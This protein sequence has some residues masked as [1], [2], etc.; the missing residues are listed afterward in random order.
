M[1]LKK[2]ISVLL[3]VGG[4]LWSGT[5]FVKADNDEPSAP[6]EKVVTEV[7]VHTGKITTATLHGYVEGFGTVQPAPATK[8]QPAAGAQLAAPSAGVVAKVNVVKGQQVNQGDVLV[9]LNS[10]LAETELARQK[11]L[12]EQQNTS[13]K[14]LQEA[15][16]QLALLRIV[17][18][19]SGTVVRVNVT[20]GQAVDLTTSVVEVMDLKRLAVT[21]EIPAAEA[22]ALKTGAETQIVAEPPVPAKISFISPTVDAKSGTVL[23][24]ASLPEAGGCGRTICPVARGHDASCGLPGGARRERGH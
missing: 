18:P 2:S 14:N 19:L 24:R 13:L 17:A 3:V 8:E 1:N 10:Q 5:P 20:P 22:A 11:K 15:E 4:L 16:A 23:V 12:Y 7:A 21:A 6:E 9:K